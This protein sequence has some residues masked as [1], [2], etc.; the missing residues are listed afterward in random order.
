[1]IDQHTIFMKKAFSLAKKG[2]GKVSPNPAVGACVVKDN[3][4]IG[5][6]YHAFFGG[7]HA[8]VE[9]LKH[10]SKE[11]LKG[12]TLY[13]TLEP[14]NHIG[15][16]PPCTDLIIE[17]GIKNV[18]IGVLDKNPLVAGS[19][20]QKLKKNGVKVLAG[21]LSSELE[22]FYRPF[23]KY[24]ITKMPF[25]TLKIAQTIDGKNGVDYGSKYLVSQK[26]L[27][28]VHKLRYYS[29]AILVG[30]NTINID[31]PYLNIRYHVKKKPVTVVVLDY[32]GKMREDANIFK[33]KGKV[34]VYNHFKTECSNQIEYVK[35]SGENGYLDL[36]E[37][38]SDLGRRGIANLLVEG[39]GTLS[40]S[41]LEKK[42]VDR[43][44]IFIAPYILGGEKHIAFG[45]SG[46]L[47]LNNAFRL[48][49]Y[50]TK[51]VGSELVITCD[52]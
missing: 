16:T 27:N 8:E 41:L 1:M 13:V 34:I 21:V 10:L 45:G 24:I 38:M 12:A 46:F 49:G 52:V 47:S 7:P 3:K 18:V 23:F 31:N 25:I 4:I 19:G 17:K 42:L 26:S 50:L 14:C 33:N 29:D 37:V 30:V 5:K 35:I 32:F 40:F 39:G 36:N 44:I 43:L 2:M 28:Y 6:G 15:K 48:E 9:A 22:C 20:I 11:E 51:F